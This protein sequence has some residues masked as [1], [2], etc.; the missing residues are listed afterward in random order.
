MPTASAV[1]ADV[2]DC[3]KH[4][5]AR[6]YLYWSDGDPDYV[7]D[8][9]EASRI[10]FVRAH[11]ADADAAFEKAAAAF[12]GASRLHRKQAEPG[13]FAFVTDHLQEKVCDEKLAQLQK[14]GLT[15]DSRI[16]IGEM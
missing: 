9:R 8:Y 3:V 4:L 13:E 14:E 10:F 5:K 15:V 1:V 7:E 16:R 2:I 12:P 11:A 6:K